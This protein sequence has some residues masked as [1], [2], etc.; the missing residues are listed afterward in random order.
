MRASAVDFRRRPAPPVDMAKRRPGDV[1]GRNREDSP[2]KSEPQAKNIQRVR[3]GGVA[4]DGLVGGVEP[5]LPGAAPTRSCRK[6]GPQSAD[7]RLRLENGVQV[8]RRRREDLRLRGPATVAVPKRCQCA[9]AARAT[10]PSVS[11]HYE[12]RR[13]PLQKHACKRGNGMRSISAPF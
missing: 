11:A 8:S 1:S 3:P 9:A 5:G 4:F 7:S 12:Q 2:R 10:R 6:E 13:Q